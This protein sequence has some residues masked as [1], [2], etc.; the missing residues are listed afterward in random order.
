MR[1]TGIQR[2]WYSRRRSSSSRCAIFLVWM[3][4]GSAVL[5]LAIIAHGVDVKPR[6]KELQE[7]IAYSINCLRA[8]EEDR[9][10][11]A[12]VSPMK[13]I[14]GSSL[15]IEGC[16]EEASLAAPWLLEPRSKCLPYYGKTNLTALAEFQAKRIGRYERAVSVIFFS[17]SLSEVT[18]NA[19][20]SMVKFGGA[21]N[22]IVACWNSFDLEACQN[23]NLPCKLQFLTIS[24]WLFY[25]SNK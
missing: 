21:S 12:L 4:L 7:G 19:I 9:L 10:Q 17:A 2:F 18:Q 11:S 20:F 8:A 16:R 1:K 22:F 3:F 13:S 6:I 25:L 5:S 15:K 24:L 23:L 14:T